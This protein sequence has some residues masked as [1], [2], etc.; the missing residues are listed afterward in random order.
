MGIC[1]LCGKEIDIPHR[2]PYCNLTY[3][4]EHHIPETHS[5]SKLPERDWANY[6]KIHD[7]R[8]NNPKKKGLF[9]S[10][11]KKFRR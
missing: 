8:L 10:L 2:C 5:C 1:Y 11:K 6:K 3:C 7:A 9:H 4:D